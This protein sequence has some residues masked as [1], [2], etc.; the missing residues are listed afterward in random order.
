MH[1]L[2]AG[3]ACIAVAIGCGGG[4]RASQADVDPEDTDPSRIDVAAGDPSPFDVTPRDVVKHDLPADASDVDA[5]D[6][7]RAS[8]DAP[9][10]DPDVDDTDAPADD[11]AAQDAPGADE[12]P[13]DT[14]VDIEPGACPVARAASIE[15][16]RVL[17]WGDDHVL[18][19]SHWPA[20]L[21]FWQNAIHWLAT[22]TTGCGSDLTTVRFSGGAVPAELVTALKA[23]GLDVTTNGALPA[24]SDPP[25]VL[26]IE[27]QGSGFL[28]AQGAALL[29]W[30]KAGGAV[31][32]MTIGFGTNDECT[33]ENP[34]LA[35]LGLA[36]SCVTPA[37]WGPV[38]RLEA[39]TITQGLTTADTPFVN[40][41]WVL[42]TGAYATTVIA[43]VGDS[44]ECPV[45]VTAP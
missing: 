8:S 37:P 23:E 44:A 22:A 38:T 2:I 27:L 17:V 14:P 7:D 13:T 20:Q 3:V 19:Q 40:G 43:D 24:A 26:A 42:E 28:P 5:T 25:S 41:R 15:C 12:S 32:V 9:H 10:P 6:D 21:P 1:S 30:V 16:G 45:Q 31:M 36:F 11:G 39:H 34:L 33:N 29:S 35:P 4:S 18:M